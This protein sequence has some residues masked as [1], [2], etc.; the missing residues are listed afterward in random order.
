MRE[1]ALVKRGRSHFLPHDFDRHD[2]LMAA[3]LVPAL[4]LSLLPF[5]SIPIDHATLMRVRVSDGGPGAV[6]RFAVPTLASVCSEV[7]FAIG[8]K[9]PE[10]GAYTKINC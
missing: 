8:E 6:H 5:A 9:H 7:R 3:V 4:L 10:S 1:H 2:V